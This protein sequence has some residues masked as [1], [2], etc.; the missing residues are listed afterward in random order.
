MQATW[1]AMPLTMPAVMIVKIFEEVSDTDRQEHILLEGK[2]VR[3]G[4]PHCGTKAESS[5][6]GKVQL[7]GP[8]VLRQKWGQCACFYNTGR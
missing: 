1:R 3:R 6:R 8:S 5:W 7:L 4:G 2:D